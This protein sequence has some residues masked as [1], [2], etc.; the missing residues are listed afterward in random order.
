[1]PIGRDCTHRASDAGVAR[2][3]IDATT[4]RGAIDATRAVGLQVRQWTSVAIGRDCTHGLGV[5]RG[6]G[7][8][9]SAQQLPSEDIVLEQTLP[10]DGV[11]KERLSDKGLYWQMRCQSCDIANRYLSVCIGFSKAQPTVLVPLSSSHRCI[12]AVQA[13]SLI[14]RHAQQIYQGLGGAC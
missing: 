11:P 7:L 5:A 10:D 14:P 8:S 13:K 2:G 9:V 1:M 3:V 6:K 12:A 4:V